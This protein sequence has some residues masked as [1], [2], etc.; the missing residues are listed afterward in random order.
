MLQQVVKSVCTRLIGLFDTGKPCKRFLKY[1]FAG[2]AGK[3]AG[4]N[5]LQVRRVDRVP[6]SSLAITITEPQIQLNSELAC[7]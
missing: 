1:E 2:L 4:F 3:F 5:N 6:A 7:V